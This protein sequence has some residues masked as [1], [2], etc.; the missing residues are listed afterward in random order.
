MVDYGEDFTDAACVIE[1]MQTAY[2]VG[3]GMLAHVEEMARQAEAE[4]APVDE[5]EVAE[6]THESDPEIADSPSD[7]ALDVADEALRDRQLAAAMPPDDEETEP[8][9]P[10]PRRM[11][12]DFEG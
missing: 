6:E 7:Q 11:R 3:K 1:N 5:L 2:Q 4:A 8:T 9:A 10:A 12:F